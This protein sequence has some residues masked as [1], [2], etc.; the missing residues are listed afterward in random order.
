M[1]LPHLNLPKKITTTW[2]RSIAH[3]HQREL[4]SSATT[5]LQT[6][7]LKHRKTHSL[8]ALK[9]TTN[10]NAASFPPTTPTH[11]S[12][13][14]DIFNKAKKFV[15]ENKNSYQRDVLS[16]EITSTFWLK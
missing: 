3:N 1:E 8:T 14:E 15:S 13:F 9:K 10:I 11:K 12:K 2:N 4:H 7:N 6:P 5:P 16:N